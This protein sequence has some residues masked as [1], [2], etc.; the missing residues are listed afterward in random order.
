MDWRGTDFPLNVNLHYYLYSSGCLCS[1][2][3]Q[4]ILNGSGFDSWL[5]P[6]CLEFPHSLC[7]CVG[8][9][10]VPQLPPTVLV[11]FPVAWN[12]V[13]HGLCAQLIVALSWLVTVGKKKKTWQISGV[14]LMTALG[15]CVPY[16]RNRM[17]TRFGSTLDLSSFLSSK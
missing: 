15:W 13:G 9:L 7:V 1:N 3:K 11:L 2:V 10:Q 14:C 4:D 17:A 12:I 5:W 6:S 16:C 8:S